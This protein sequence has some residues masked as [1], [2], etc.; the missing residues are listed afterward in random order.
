MEIVA[1]DINFNE[2]DIN[3]LKFNTYGFAFLE[4]PAVYIL[5]NENNSKVYIGQTTSIINRLKQ[6]LI[7][8]E[9]KEFTNVYIFS[10]EYFNQS[11]I[12]NIEAILINLF[13]NTINKT[14]PDYKNFHDYYQKRE[15]LET[16]LS[17]LKKKGIENKFNI[18]F[19]GVLENIDIKIECLYNEITIE[20][21][22]FNNKEIDKLEEYKYPCVYLLKSDKKIYIGETSNIKTRL[23]EHYK[24]KSKIFDKVILIRYDKFNNSVTYDLETSLLNYFLADEKYE[25]YNEKQKDLKVIYSYYNQSYYHNDVFKEIWERLKDKKIVDNTIEHL[26]TKDLFKISPFISLT[27]EQDRIINKILNSL[28]NDQKEIFIIRGEAG[29]G[30]S[31]L[32]SSLYNKILAKYETDK[33]NENYL[34]VNHEEML[35]IYH[36]MSKYLPLMIKKNILKPTTFVNKIIKAYIS[37]IDEG[38]TLLSSKDN[39]NN[40]KQ[41]N[42]LEEIIKKSQKTILI[43]D[44][45]QFLKLKS[46]WDD[47]KLSEILRKFN[48]IKIHKFKLDSQLRMECP[49]EI[50]DWIDNV[51]ENKKI[52]KLPHSDD[53]EL[54]VFD[55]CKEMHEAIKEKNK[56][57]GLSRMISTFD[58]IHK[59]DGKEYYIEEDELKLPW[60]ILKQDAWTQRVETIDEIGSIY[61]IQGFDLNYA[62]VILGPSLSYDFDKDELIVKIDEYKDTEAFRVSDKLKDLEDSKIKELK[63]KIILNSLNVLLK[64][65]IKGLYLCA[66]DKKLKQALKEKYGH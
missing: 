31:V 1:Y 38:H 26:N 33:L 30:K 16:V 61:S 59:K 63:E 13:S 3:N 65:P 22:D 5:Y 23:K 43:F 39:Y 9:K 49:K 55:S 10:A 42:H 44:E 52:D 8:P 12:E 53:F 36:L 48:N 45:K 24:T 62:G 25:I 17:D 6:H 2:K 37:L 18:S 54:K 4:Y 60:N 47:S 11:L 19:E 32:L 50:I 56:Q 46:Y 66:S 64:R 15:L 27:Q 20:E 29:S 40:F 41:D 21:F 35:K 7:S 51:V 58:Y 28:D 14:S 57:Y 34:L